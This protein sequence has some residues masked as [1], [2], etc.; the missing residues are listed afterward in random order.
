MSAGSHC[1][2]A[3]SCGIKCVGKAGHLQFCIIWP[4]HPRTSPSA[5]PP[6]L[7]PQVH[8]DL[9][10]A[11]VLLKSARSDRRGFGCRLAD[12]GLS[13]MLGQDESHVDTQVGVGM[14]GWQGGLPE[15]EW[16]AG[17]LAGLPEGG[18]LAGW[19]QLGWAG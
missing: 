3:A 18:W 12:F 14:G 5:R 9:K 1:V 7:L 8:G 16:L 15:S 2:M 6:R 13:R 11:N 10:P 4:A 17:W 19:A